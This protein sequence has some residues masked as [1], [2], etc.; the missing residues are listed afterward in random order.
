MLSDGQKHVFVVGSALD[1]VDSNQTECA[2]SNG[3]VLELQTPPPPNAEAV[4]LV[5]LASK[6]GNECAKSSTVTVQFSELQ[7]MQ[8]HMRE[9]IDQGLQELKDKQ[10]TKG[11]PPLPPSA[12]SQPVP[13]H[14]A[15]VAPPADPNAGAEIQQQDQQVD[16][17]VKDVSND[18]SQPQEGVVTPPPQG[19]VVTPPPQ[20]RDVAPPPQGGVVTPPPQGGDVVPP[21]QGSDVAPPPQ[22]GVVP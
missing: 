6:G 7:E 4:D 5:V 11:L 16:Q 1:V 2:L 14:Y 10:G 21:P 3:D 20:G 12:Q 13:A 17:A 9:V 22:G 15:E 18:A 19:G 8:N